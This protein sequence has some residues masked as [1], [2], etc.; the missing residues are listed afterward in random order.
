[1]MIVVLGLGI[2]LEIWSMS[3]VFG[4]LVELGMFI[5][6]YFLNWW[7]LRIVMLVFFLISVVMFLVVSYGVWWCVLISLLNVFE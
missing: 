6:V 7:V 1:M 4:M 5:V 2:V 3:L